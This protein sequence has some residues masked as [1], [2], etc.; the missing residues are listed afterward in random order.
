MYP[1]KNVQAVF[2]ISADV[3]LLCLRISIFGEGFQNLF[4]YNLYSNRTLPLTLC[5][6][7]YVAV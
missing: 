7:I 3:E 5:D 2:L 4:R 1:V 6:C